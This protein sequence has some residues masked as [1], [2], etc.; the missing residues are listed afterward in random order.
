M[1]A[2][3]LGKSGIEVSALGMG[4]W[5]IGDPWT[6]AQPRRDSYPAEWG[7]TNDEDSIR[8]IHT[9][10]GLGITFFDTAANYGAG[11]S[12]VVFGKALKGLR[13]KAVIATKFGHIVNEETNTVY[14][15]SDQILGNMRSDV[16]N[17]LRRL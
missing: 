5:A 14:G 9:A 10:L 13:G 17:S 7:Y 2:R 6:W 12:E 11:H 3:T 15:D 16:A 4:C 1:I 8:A